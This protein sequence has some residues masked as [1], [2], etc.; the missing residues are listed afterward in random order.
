MSPETYTPTLCGFSHDDVPADGVCG[1][2]LV[3]LVAEAYT[4]MDPIIDGSAITP[5]LASSVIAVHELMTGSSVEACEQARCICQHLSA[6][7][8][9]YLEPVLSARRVI[10]KV[11]A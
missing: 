10:R 9:Q 5:D 4:A 7:W 1:R 8:P 11:N 6:A 3:I 2:C